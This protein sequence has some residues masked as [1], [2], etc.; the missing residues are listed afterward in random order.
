MNRLEFVEILNEYAF[1][2]NI[3]PIVDYLNIVLE[4]NCY[5]NELDLIF[6]AIASTQL[7]GFLSYLTDEE[8]ELFFD[9][10]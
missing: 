7:Y 3:K 8:K 1:E 6:M 9:C 5:E 4:K 10:D 2:N